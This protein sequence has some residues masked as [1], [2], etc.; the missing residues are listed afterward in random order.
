MILIAPETGA[1]ILVARLFAIFH[2][3]CR[4]DDGED[5]DH[6]PRA[7][8]FIRSLLGSEIELDPAQCALLETAIRGHTAG[9]ISYDP[10]IGTC[11][12]ADRL[13]LGRVGII[14]DSR[15]MSTSAGRK[16]ATLGTKY[17]YK[18]K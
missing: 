2:D 3:C 9:R 10:T 12:D 1:D 17:L 14:P 13:D 15:H 11:W 5:L 6:G 4:I 16:I 8:T 18:K 7:A